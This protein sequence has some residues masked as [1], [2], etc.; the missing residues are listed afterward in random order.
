MPGRGKNARFAGLGRAARTSAASV[1]NNDEMRSAA[2][3]AFFGI[4]FG[5][6]NSAVALYH[7]G[8]PVQL[9]HFS[10]RGEALPSCR[11]GGRTPQRNGDAKS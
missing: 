1:R 10:F 2:G 4:D 5:T 11:S 3:Q 9:A 7:P 6:T 8:L